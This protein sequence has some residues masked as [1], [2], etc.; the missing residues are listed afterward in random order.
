MRARDGRR[1]RREKGA[2]SPLPTFLQQICNVSLVP[3][4]HTDL[5]FVCQECLLLRVIDE[6][7][8]EEVLQNS[9]VGQHRE[10]SQLQAPHPSVSRGSD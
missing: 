5:A 8:E 7:V 3:A 2:S 10:S 6:R 4:P 1:K 9:M